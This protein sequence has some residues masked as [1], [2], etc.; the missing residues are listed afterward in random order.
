MLADIKQSLLDD[1][2][3]LLS[4][5]EHFGYCNFTV[6]PAYIQFGRDEVSSKKSIVIRRTNNSYLYVTDYPRGI[7]TDIFNYIGTQRNVEFK[8]IMFVVKD[9]LGIDNLYMPKKQGIFGGFYDSIHKNKEPIIKVYDETILER[10][11]PNGN[12]RFCK[13][14]IPIET[15]K[16]FNIRYD[17]ES[18]SIIIPIYAPY[19]Q[20]MGIKARRNTDVLDGESKYFYLVPCLMSQTLYG[21]SVNYSYLVENTIYIFESEKSVM[22][23]YSYDIRNCVAMGSSSIS[24]KQI[25][26]LMELQPKAIIFMH[27][28]GFE[29]EGIMNNIEKVKTYSRFQQVPLGYWDYTKGNCDSKVSASDM[30]KDILNNIVETQLVMIDT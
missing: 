29:M 22:Q 13:D 20:L 23:C 3:K 28:E 15:Q 21:Y 14:N 4:L 11:N 1:V 25:R 27:D 26:L 7:H 8:E 24:E 9:I 19:G 18:Q 12:E 10:Y 30:G 17:V 2:D 5:L 16:I 6:R